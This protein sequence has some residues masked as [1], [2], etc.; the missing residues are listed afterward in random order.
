MLSARVPKCLLL[1]VNKPK[2]I[3]HCSRLTTWWLDFDRDYV[4]VVK[5]CFWTVSFILSAFY[6]L[7]TLTVGWTDWTWNNFLLALLLCTLTRIMTGK[8]TRWT[9]WFAFFAR[10][11][12]I[13]FLLSKTIFIT[14][15]IAWAF[16]IILFADA[17]LVDFFLSQ[18]TR[19]LLVRLFTS[20]S[21]GN[22]FLS[23][24]AWIRIAWIR[25]LFIAFF[26]CASSRNIVSG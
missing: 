1:T 26:A 4:I 8:C 20:T 5:F 10:T 2:V 17:T 23:E 22:F 16:D 9:L 14:T 13:N 18:N 7:A 21:V 11:S 24:T 25:A 12:L 19:A 6:F 15:T 3:F